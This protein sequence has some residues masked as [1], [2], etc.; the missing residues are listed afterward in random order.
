M[1]AVMASWLRRLAD[2]LSPASVVPE[3]LV[4]VT[5]A[6]VAHADTLPHTGHFKRAVV[7]KTLGQRYPAIRRRDLALAVELAVRDRP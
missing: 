5:R 3:W 2:W 6:A 1:R 4:Q 7:L